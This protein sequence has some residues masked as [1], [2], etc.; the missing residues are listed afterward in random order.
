MADE[1]YKTLGVSKQATDDDSNQA[2]QML[3]ALLDWPQATYAS[4]LELADGRARVT[5]ETDTGEEIL[6]SNSLG[7]VMRQCILLKYG[8]N[9]A[10]VVISLAVVPGEAVRDRKLRPGR[11]AS[12]I[13]PDTDTPAANSPGTLTLRAGA[14]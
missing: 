5:R 11:M 14:H 7:T 13:R 2:G 3:A 4:K 9:T 6:E 10:E 1:L 8:Q 12:V